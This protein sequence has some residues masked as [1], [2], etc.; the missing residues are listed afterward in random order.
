MKSSNLHQYIQCDEGFSMKLSSVR[1]TV[2]IV[3]F[4][5]LLGFL[6]SSTAHAASLC[7]SG[8]GTA[9][10]TSPFVNLDAGDTI[11]GRVV[12]DNAS[13]KVQVVINTAIGATTSNTGVGGVGAS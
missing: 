11:I 4:A 2:L 7:L 10:F 5:A 12:A 8:R 6:P 3:L 9:A 1:L 13:D